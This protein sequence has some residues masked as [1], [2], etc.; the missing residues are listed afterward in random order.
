MG[1]FVHEIL[2][3]D[4]GSTDNTPQIIEEYAKKYPHLIRN[5]SKKENVG[6]SENMK[7]CFMEAKGKYIAVLEGDDYWTDFKKLEK[8]MKFLEKNKD[9]SMVFSRINLLN[10]VGNIH[11]LERHNGLSSK[12]SGKDF[13]K[14]PS[15]IVNFSCCMFKTD[16]LK[17]L[18]EILYKDRLSE[19]SLAFYLEKF[20]KFGF[21]STPL[22][23]YRQHASGVWSGADR[24]KQLQSGL[25]CRQTAY[26]VC[27]DKYKPQL[28]KIIDEQYIKP[29]NELDD[30]VA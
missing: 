5:I 3:S 19:I 25:Q 7:R 2:I 18:P 12:L 1:V 22:S 15:L 6:I 30:K 11:L 20:G 24:K 9:C 29:L 23:V 8:Q 13:I 26:E 27:R 17:K 4:D 10:K 14:E 16:L 28:K 21:I